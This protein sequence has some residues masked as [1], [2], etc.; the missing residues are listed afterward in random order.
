M[1]SVQELDDDRFIRQEAARVSGMSQREFIVKSRLWQEEIS[2]RAAESI[3]RRNNTRP[4]PLAGFDEYLANLGDG[5]RQIEGLA[6]GIETIDHLIGGLNKF[7]LMAARG[8][9]G[10][11]TI[12]VQMALGVLATEGVPI[13]Y[14]SYEMDKS[15]IYTLMLQNLCKDLPYKLTRNEI[16]LHGNSEHSIY[17][18][19]STDAIAES[20]AALREMAP[21]LY[22]ISS[23]DGN[24][25]LERMQADIE[26]VTKAH[27]IA[28]LVIIDS[29]QDLVQPDQG[30]Q[31]AAEAGIAQKI[32]ELQQATGATFLAI[33]QKA[34]GGSL[35]DPYG[36]VLGSVAWIHKPTA[37]IELSGVY[38]LMRGIK[39]DLN[40]QIAYRK[41]ADN[42]TMPRPVV[43]SVIKGRNNGY[44]KISLKHYGKHSYFEEGRIK[45]YD[46]DENNLYDLNGVN[47]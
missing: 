20:S 44:G 25:N 34:K 36:S 21:R 30:N 2:K 18:Q 24:P 3:D 1:K 4:E 29:V 47:Q 45:D 15:D 6:T 26:H 16:V 8:G 43:M 14:Y 11:S 41:L 31:T 35:D 7:V 40:A 10:K 23:K 13:L 19:A 37:V 38:D 46:T 27:D 17:T 42:S 28:P 39:L 12:A 9:T 33:S 5:S 22:V 32:V